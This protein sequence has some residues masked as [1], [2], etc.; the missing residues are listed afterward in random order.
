MFLDCQYKAQTKS[1]ALSE[2]IKK[3]FVSQPGQQ[4]HENDYV[5]EG[6]QQ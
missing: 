5:D 4:Q 2:T 6:E 3:I 1:I